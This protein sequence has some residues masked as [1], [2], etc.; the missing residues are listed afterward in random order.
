MGTGFFTLTSGH[1][2]L[3]TDEWAQVSLHWREVLPVTQ[4]CQTAEWNT[5]TTVVHRS[6]SWHGLFP[7]ISVSFPRFLIFRNCSRSNSRTFPDEWV[8]V[9]R[10]DNGGPS[11]ECT[12]DTRRSGALVVASV[13]HISYTQTLRRRCATKHTHTKFTKTGILLDASCSYS[14]VEDGLYRSTLWCD[15][16]DLEPTE[17][18]TAC[19]RKEYFLPYVTSNHSIFISIKTEINYKSTLA[20]ATIKNLC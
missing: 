19:K 15:F 13:Q 2:F 6:L 11:W 4:P 18:N 10:Y 16:S 20:P 1:R 8:P 3:Y 9:K 12:D 7:N 17:F 5:S 14:Y